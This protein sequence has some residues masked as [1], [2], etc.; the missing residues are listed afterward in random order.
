MRIELCSAEIPASEGIPDGMTVDADGFVWTAVWFGGRLKRFAP[1]GGLDR[2]V[3]FP[4]AQTSC[5]TFGGEDYSEMFIT[6][7]AGAGADRFAPP[8]YKPVADRRGGALY[9]CRIEGVRGAPEFRSRLRF[10]AG[11]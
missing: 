9:S 5:V 2:E 6:T 1:D 11:A 4:V 8:G 3:F 10:G 7:A